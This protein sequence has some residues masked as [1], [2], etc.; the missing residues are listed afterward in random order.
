MHGV[1]STGHS[2][3]IFH[4]ARGS[5]SLRMT[6]IWAALMPRSCQLGLEVQREGAYL[7]F[8]K[9][10][11]MLQ[12]RDTLPNHKTLKKARPGRGWVYIGVILG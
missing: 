7:D 9:G 8:G 5:G 1:I 6:E 12:A 4:M 10:L 2:F 11:A 3:R